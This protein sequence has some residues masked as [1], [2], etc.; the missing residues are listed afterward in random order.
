M[1]CLPT[2]AQDSSAAVT[3]GVGHSGCSLESCAYGEVLALLV[4]PPHVYKTQVTE[5][6]LSLDTHSG[7]RLAAAFSA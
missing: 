1:C 2:C 5:V 6:C 4:F 3:V 7:R